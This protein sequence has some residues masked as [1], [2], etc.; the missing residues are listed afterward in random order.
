MSTQPRSQC[1]TCDRYRSPFSPENTR[2]LDGPFCAAFP[3]GIPNAV[4]AN[5]LDHREPVDGD[6]GIRW[7]SNGQP[8]PE[9][10]LA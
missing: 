1:A 8:F 2:G 7:T 6:H 10:A 4:Y 9:Y 5:V 3:D